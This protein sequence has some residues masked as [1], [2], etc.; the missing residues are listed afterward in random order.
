MKRCNLYK[1]LL[2]ALA[3]SAALFSCVDIDPTVGSDYLPRDHQMRIR[4]DS[5]F[6]VRTYNVTTDSVISSMEPFNL[7]GSYRNP[8]TRVQIDAGLVFQMQRP[9]RLPQNDSLL[10]TAPVIDSALMRFTVRDAQGATDLPQ[11]FDLYEMDLRIRLDSNYYHNFDPTPY[12]SDRPIAST[13][14][15]GQGDLEFTIDDG[16]FLRRLADTTGYLVDTLFKQRF[17]SF[18][19][20]PR[21]SGIDASL[22]RIDLTGQ[23]GEV[24]PLSRLE[25]WY[26]NAEYPD[27]LLRA[28]YNLAPYQGEDT[29]PNQTINVV[30]RDYTNAVATLHLND[31]D[32]PVAQPLVESFGGIYTRLEFTRTSVEALKEKARQEGFRDIAVNKA[33]LYIHYPADALREQMPERL[34]IYTDF[35]GRKGIVDYDWYIE[36]ESLFSGRPQE[37]IYDGMIR[38]ARTLYRMDITEFVQQLIKDDGESGSVFLAPSYETPLIYPNRDNWSNPYT[39]PLAGYGSETPP[40]LVITYTML[41]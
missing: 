20:V 23:D 14:H 22:Y 34:G 25:A 38:P 29:P 31:P 41:R 17:K 15:S 37:L 40:L 7:V 19:I 12:L 4:R 8:A 10:G 32:T 2:G 30:R 13:T 1:T 5:S 36:Y 21:A 35:I 11:T 26:H 33:D 27:T 16:D 24:T 6:V 39:A 18:Y 28:V 9:G 3:A